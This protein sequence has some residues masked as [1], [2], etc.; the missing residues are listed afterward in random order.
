MRSHGCSFRQNWS[1]FSKHLPSSR[2]IAEIDPLVGRELPADLEVRLVDLGQPGVDDLLVKLLLLLEAED[3][4]GLLGEHPDDPVEH[5][6][7]EVGVVDGDSVDGPVESLAEGDPDL[8]PVERLGATVEPDDD[9]ALLRL[10]RVEIPDDQRVDRRLAHEPLGHGAELAVADGTEPE[11]AHDD[12]IVVLALHVLDQ[13]LV[14]LAVHHPRL[15][16][17]PGG[18][19]LLPH[20][21]EVRVRDQLE[22]HR[23]QRVVDLPLALQLVLVPV[24]LGQ[25]V[26]HLLEA[27]VVKPRR[28][29]VAT[30]QGRAEGSPELHGQVDGAVGVVRVVDRHVDLLEHGGLPWGRRGHVSSN[31]TATSLSDEAGAR[32]RPGGISSMRHW[33][34]TGAVTLPRILPSPHAPPGRGCP[35]PSVGSTRWSSASQIAL[36]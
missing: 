23:D 9:R 8:E 11:G 28:V 30:G 20:H 3:L 25:R 17:E 19:R 6:V 36:L 13:G 33:P 7:V 5:G 24:L 15:E 2:V 34:G 14:V 35:A 4:R 10:E 27:V 16:R 1:T 26:L 32:W 18:L 21:L 31:S 12:E 22:A 29:D